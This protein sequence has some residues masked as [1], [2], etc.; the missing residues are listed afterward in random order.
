MPIYC[1]IFYFSFLDI[2][3]NDDD[4]DDNEDNGE[5]RSHYKHVYNEDPR[6]VKAKWRCHQLHARKF[7]RNRLTL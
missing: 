1:I 2:R 6:K 5:A 7:S 4:D 3:G